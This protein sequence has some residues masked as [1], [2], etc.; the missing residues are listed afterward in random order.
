[1]KKILYTFPL[2]LGTISVYT[3]SA[4][5]RSLEEIPQLSCEYASQFEQCMIANKNGTTRSI[6]DFVCIQ[7]SRMDDV[8]DQIILDTEFRKIEEEEILPYIEQLSE[9]KDAYTGNQIFRPIDDIAKNFWPEGVY[10]KKFKELCNGGILAKRAECSEKIINNE[11]GF[12]LKWSETSTACMELVKT[13]LDIYTQVSTDILKKNKAEVWL[14]HH[15]ALVQDSR[16]KYDEVFQSMESLKGS[17]WRL[18]EGITH[19]TPHPLQ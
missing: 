9:Q 18:A 17:W 16:E 5:T 12:R 2:L 6:E 4:S 10:Y 7:S 8:L 14:D 13:K 19:Y 11:A 1:M 3:L 15:K